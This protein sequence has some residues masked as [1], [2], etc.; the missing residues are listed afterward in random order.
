MAR[1]GARED[2]E[3]LVRGF[4]E[5]RFGGDLLRRFRLCPKRESALQQAETVQRDL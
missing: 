5:G 4:E 3:R 2:H 1:Q